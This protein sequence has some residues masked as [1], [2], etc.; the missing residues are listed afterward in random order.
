MSLELHRLRRYPRVAAILGL[1]VVVILAGVT[2][3]LLEKTRNSELKAELLGRALHATHRIERQLAY[4]LSATYTL[5]TLV[6]RAGGSL[7]EFDIVADELIRD[8][9][10]VTALQLAP[11]GV[12]QQIYPLAGHERALGHDLLQDPKRRVESLTAI[13]D[14]A[15]TLAG[16]FELIQGGTAVAGRLPVLLPDDKGTETFWGF[17][18]ALV[19]LQDLLQSSEIDTALGPDT[20]YQL[21]RVDPTTGR[22]VIFAGSVDTLLA[23]PLSTPIRVP[24]GEWALSVRPRQG[25]IRFYQQPMFYAFG[26]IYVMMLLLVQ[27]IVIQQAQL[28]SRALHD[29]LTDLPARALFLE[30]LGNA[31][32]HAKRHRSRVAVYFV[33]LDN[34]KRIN[35]QHG[36]AVGDRVLVAIANV[37]TDAIRATDIAARYGGDEFVVLAP[38][39]G[40]RADAQ[41]LR[42]KLVDALRTTVN[43]DGQGVDI[44]TSVGFSLF[45]DDATSLAPLIDEADSDMYRQKQHLRVVE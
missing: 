6:K 24:N 29:A 13:Q 34:F 15:L 45:P 18:I 44:S 40:S 16:P 39:I 5:A 10:G 1:S 36:H 33:D 41:T 25:W 9:G 43:V 42:S 27:I 3:Y 32:A 21:S 38:D 17:T 7:P 19:Y 37:V 31:I 28:S 14:E 30:H 8:I 22:T 23:E 12:V 20:D 26:G 11:G 2:A 35:D 4:S